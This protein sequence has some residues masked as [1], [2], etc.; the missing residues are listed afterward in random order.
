MKEL[1]R[2]EKAWEH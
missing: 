2:M 1:Q